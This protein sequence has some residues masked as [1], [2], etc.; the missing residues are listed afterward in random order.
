MFF[1][2]VSLSAGLSSASS[3]KPRR[4]E[5]GLR[6]SCR[7]SEE[8][9]PITDIR[10]ARSSFA[11]ACFSSLFAFTSSVLRLPQRLHEA[12]VGA[13][14]HG[15]H[16]AHHRQR[17]RAVLADDPV[18]VPPAD[19]QGPHGAAGDHGGAAGKVVDQRHL[20]EEVAGAV[21]GEQVG[22][23]CRVVL[24]DLHGA[25]ADDVQLVGGVPLGEHGVARREASPR[26]TGRPPFPGRPRRG[27]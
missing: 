5:M 26:G 11:C 22:L 7:M 16:R 12:L 2:T 10:S 3:A 27:P 13:S 4:M 14:H 24:P 25:L 1:F 19:R 6:M 8:N 23:G 9:L 15:G 18:E 17:D 21:Q 20:T